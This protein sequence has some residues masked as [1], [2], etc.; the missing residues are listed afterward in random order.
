MNYPVVTMSIMSYHY[1]SDQI[2]NWVGQHRELIRSMHL[3]D[4]AVEDSVEI[5]FETSELATL[6]KLR[7]HL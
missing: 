7:F 3:I 2:T 6:F 4:N 1:Q 5:C